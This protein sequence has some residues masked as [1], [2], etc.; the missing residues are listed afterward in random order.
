MMLYDFRQALRPAALLEAALMNRMGRAAAVVSMV[1]CT[2]AALICP[3]Q[4][5]SKR[6]IEAQVDNLLSKMTLD[7]KLSMLS[8]DGGMSTH[9]IPRLGIPIM[10]TTDGPQGVR[11][12]MVDKFTNFPC[13]ICMGA[14]WDPGLIERLGKAMGNETRAK[15]KDC[16][17]LLGPCVNIHRT[18]QGG[19]NCESFS[20]DPYLAARIAVGYIKGVQSQNAAACIKHYACNNQEFDRGAINVQVDERALREIYLPAFRAAATEAHVWSLMTSYNCVNGFHSS[21]NKYLV[22]DILKNEWNWDGLVMSDWGGV[23]EVV[24]VVNAGN[25]LEMSGGD[26]LIPSKLHDAL[27]KGEISEKQI[28]ESVRRILRCMARTGLLEENAKPGPDEVDWKAH[29]QLAR[30]AAAK[31]IVLLKNDGAVLPLDK[32]KIRSIALIGPN[33]AEARASVSGSGH[34]SQADPVSPLD[35]IKNFVGSSVEV[36]YA[37]GPKPASAMRGL[38]PLPAD[39]IVTQDG[40]QGFRG[41]YFANKDFQGTPKVRT[42]KK[43]DLTWDGESP[44]QGV[45]GLNCSARWTGTLTA[46][47]TGDYVFELVSDDG[48]KLYLDDKLVIDNWGDHGPQSRTSAVKF[49]AGK[50]YALRVDYYNAGGGATIYLGWKTPEQDSEDSLLQSAV[51]AA[52]KSDVAVVFAGVWDAHEGEGADRAD[53]TLALPDSQEYLIRKV[54][55]VNKNTIVVLSGGTICDISRCVRKVP[56]VIQAWYPGVEDGNVLADI[57]FGVVNPSGKLPDTFARVRADYPDFGNYPGGPGY[58]K[59]AEGIFVGYRHFDKAGIEPLFPFGHGLSYTSFDYSDMALSSGQMH[60]GGKVQVSMT[61]SNTGSRYGEEV[62]QLYVG[63]LQPTVERPVKEL[64]GFRKVGL[65]PGEE[66]TVIFDLDESALSFYDVSAKK[67]RANSGRYEI[68]IGASSRDL[69]LKKVMELQ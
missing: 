64:K 13:G 4:A 24:G 61:L 53:S 1:C 21:A 50:Q 57:L 9:G 5:S 29:R 52:A 20:E 40:E 30:E 56:S 28:D 58:V 32:S 54:A 37:S 66:K 44:C 23:H 42:D 48:S 2:V 59:Y 43:L 12:G 27:N 38:A 18:P 60:R 67:W 45:P 6:S 55:E 63:E 15:S 22:N 25:D 47:R 7:E 49:E 17:V 69:R 16:R 35:A 34:V 51:E 46:P 62:V 68:A 39:A 41:E 3:S 10:E 31:G 19:R 8:G 14:T 65:K 33:A 36:N 11:G 26:W